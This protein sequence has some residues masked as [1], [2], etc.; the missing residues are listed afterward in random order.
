M[1]ESPFFDS[2]YIFCHRNRHI[3]SD[4]KVTELS[5]T[6]VREHTPSGSKKYSYVCTSEHPLDFTAAPLGAALLVPMNTS[7]IGGGDA[8]REYMMRTPLYSILE[9]YYD[10]YPWTPDFD[11]FLVEGVPI[12][13][14]Q[15]RGALRLQTEGPYRKVD[16]L[17]LNIDSPRLQS[18]IDSEREVVSNV[19][20]PLVDYDSYNIVLLGES[21]EKE[22]MSKRMEKE[23]ADEGD[24]SQQQGEPQGEPSKRQ[25]RANKMTRD[26]QRRADADRKRL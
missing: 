22:K 17:C 20:P 7:S 10:R 2:L 1:E 5:A 24:A 13:A 23:S 14:S 12:I 6:H 8:E 18:Y 9:K 21:K 25:Y 26:K 16:L 15:F 19:E 4:V 11:G 3:Y